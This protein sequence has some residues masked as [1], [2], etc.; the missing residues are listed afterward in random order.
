MIIFIDRIIISLCILYVP[1][2]RSRPILPFE[3]KRPRHIASGDEE[4]QAFPFWV[5]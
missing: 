3:S 5:E 4:T 2:S 1:F